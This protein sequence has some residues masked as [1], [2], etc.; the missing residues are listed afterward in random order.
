MAIILSSCVHSINIIVQSNDNIIIINLRIR[1][2]ELPIVVSMPQP[3]SYKFEEPEPST[4]VM[5]PITM[6]LELA[7]LMAREQ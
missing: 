4:P 6:Q 2:K 3:G 7:K 1:M 5:S